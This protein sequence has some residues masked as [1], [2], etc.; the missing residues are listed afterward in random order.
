MGFGIWDCRHS[1]DTTFHSHPLILFTMMRCKT[2]G[3]FSR[4]RNHRMEALIILGSILLL[5]RIPSSESFIM[6][7]F[8]S[9][10][11]FNAFKSTCTNTQVHPALSQLNKFSTTMRSSKASSASIPKVRKQTSKSKIKAKKDQNRKWI[12]PTTT[13][14]GSW[15]EFYIELQSCVVQHGHAARS[16]PVTLG[17]EHSILT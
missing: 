11:S 4:R 15:R 10:R 8:N 16:F 2:M 6:T 14:T 17:L 7:P 3:V 5:L 13:I 9:G 1:H 12:N